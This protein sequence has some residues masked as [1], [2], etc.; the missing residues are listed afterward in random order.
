MLAVL[1]TFR[2]TTAALAIIAATATAAPAATD[3]AAAPRPGAA[4]VGQ[5][6]Q[7][8]VIDTRAGR[9][10]YRCEQ[11]DG[12]PCPVW[13]W[14]YNDDV[15]KGQ[16]TPT[17]CPDCPS[18]PA[19]ST[20]TSSAPAATTPPAATPTPGDDTPQLALTGPPLWYLLLGASALVL[21]GVLFVS[22]AQ[23]RRSKCR[24]ARR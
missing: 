7:T 9:Q 3:H 23:P 5:S 4:C 19:A 11:R 6:G 18:S 12:D 22:L 2:L 8:T 16:P 24:P 21:A 10:T 17:R 14:V 1:R 15:P 20:A 13:H